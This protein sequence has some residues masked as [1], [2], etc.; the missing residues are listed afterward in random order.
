MPSNMDKPHNH[1]AAS[2]GY[3]TQDANPRG[4]Y[5]FLVS[6]SLMI[7]FT[8]LLCWGLFRYFSIRYAPAKPASPFAETR[9]L[10]PN[11]QLQVYPQEDL[12]KFQEQQRQSLEM[13]AW[14]NPQAGTVRIPI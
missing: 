1:Q 8:L 12:S 3:E 5:G 13:Y 6:L 2:P 4:V 11:P 10:P 9:Q 14:E 7:V